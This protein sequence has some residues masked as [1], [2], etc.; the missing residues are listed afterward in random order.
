[1]QLTGKFYGLFRDAKTNKLKITFLLDDE[2]DDDEL[3]KIEKIRKAKK[4]GI[5][6][7]KWRKKRTPDANACAWALISKI[8]KKMK[9]GKN[10]VYRNAIR[11]LGMY[12]A[13]PVKNLAVE[14]FIE[15][16]TSKGLGWMCETFQ[17]RTPGYTNVICYYGSSSYDTEEMGRFIDG[18]IE[19]CRTLKIDIPSKEN[20]ESVKREWKV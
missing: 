16:W 14:R 4:L 11:E 17:S 15:V 12:E 1:M 10:E 7:K 19:D 5:E 3:S 18:L 13:V 9:L 8:A 20:I 2:L 6:V